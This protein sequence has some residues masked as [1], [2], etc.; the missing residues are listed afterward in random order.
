MNYNNLGEDSL[1]IILLCSNLAL[2][3]KVDNVKPFTAIEYSKF[4][5]IVLNSTIK[6]PGNL[7]KL[8]KEEMISTLLMS[9][10]EAERVVRLLAKSGQLSFQLNELNN[11]G[12]NIITRA[13]NKYP[14]VLKEKL[15]EKCPPVLYCCGDIN[16]LKNELIGVVGSRNIDIDGADFTKKISKKIVTEEYA[17]VSGGAKGTDS[18]AQE[19]V[20]ENGGKVVAFIADSMLTRIKK[21]EVREAITSKKLL[22]ISAINPKAGFTVYSAMDR[23][24]YIY[25]ISK[26]TVVISSDYNKGGTWAGAMENL[27]NNWVPL[28]VRSDNNIPKGNTELIKKGGIEIKA[29]NLT[30]PFISF[31]KN[32]QEAE[33]GYYDGDLL[34]LVNNKIEV[35]KK[36]V[37]DRKAKMNENDKVCEKEE[38]KYEDIKEKSYDAYELLIDKIIEVLENPL[39]LDEFKSLLNINKKQASEWLN[40]AID[41][42]KI[43]KVSKPIRYIAIS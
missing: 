40:R 6:R 33:S 22:I 10:T 12:I 28:I 23:N 31:I 29:T 13:D 15:K 19:G 17:L 43:K 24:K 21:K 20:L 8:S 9:D 3:N 42:G 39:T 25:C 4:A 27:K 37:V 5:R 11:I 14:K 2:D 16:I 32:T 36:L 1:A 18:I 35:E 38:V 26:C 30:K 34:S 41:E 7:F